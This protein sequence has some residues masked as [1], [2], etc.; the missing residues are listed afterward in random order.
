MS[1]NLEATPWPGAYLA[2]GTAWPRCD[3]KPAALRVDRGDQQR[4]TEQ[5]TPRRAY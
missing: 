4:N 1:T 2:A 5:G 3:E